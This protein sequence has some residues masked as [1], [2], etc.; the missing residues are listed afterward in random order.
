MFAQFS[1]RISQII[2]WRPVCVIL[3]LSFMLYGPCSFQPIREGDCRQII[4]PELTIISIK[5]SGHLNS[6]KNVTFYKIIYGTN[7]LPPANEGTVFTGVCLEG[8]GR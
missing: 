8:V 5:H 3:D 4:F 7:L 6:S 1:G 2:G